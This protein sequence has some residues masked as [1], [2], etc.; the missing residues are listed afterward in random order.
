VHPYT[1]RSEAKRLASDF[2]GDPKAEYKLF[3]NLGVDGVFSDFPDT[4]K[5]ARDQ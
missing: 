1:F 3:Y 5:A 4:A 2:K